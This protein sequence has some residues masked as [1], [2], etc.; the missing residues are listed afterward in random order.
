MTMQVLLV[1][2][3]AK[4]ATQLENAL[5]K[6][7]FDVTTAINGL[8]GYNKAQQTRFDVCVVDHLMPL[9]DGRQLL[10]NLSAL[11]DNQPSFVVFM[12]TQ[13]LKA[14]EQ[15]PE[16]QF[17]DTILSKPISDEDFIALIHSLTEQS[18]E[19]A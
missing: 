7:G 4:V 17:A 10:K 14:V 15:L 5:T 19:V 6:A 18:T 9:M 11:T 13:D 8:D 2:D 1:E 3:N 16:V 12:S